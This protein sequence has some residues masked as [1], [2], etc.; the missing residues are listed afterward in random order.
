M[1]N[2][3]SRLV[4]FGCFYALCLLVQAVGGYFTQMSVQDWYPTLYKSP[5]TPPGMYFG[6]VWTVLYFLMALAATRVF[7]KTQTV[8]CHALRWWLI[9]L[10]LG[11]IW[12]IMFFGRQQIESGMLII[13]ANLVAIGVTLMFFRRVDRWA[14]AMIAPLLLWVGFAS[15]LNGFIVLHN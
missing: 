5:L 6:I 2:I 9:Q 12:S 13:L 3:T 4:T 10:L 8:R 14:G 7:H 11:L 15:Y 1:K